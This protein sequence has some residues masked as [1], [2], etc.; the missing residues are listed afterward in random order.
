M[1]DKKWNLSICGICPEE[2]NEMSQ[3][4]VFFKGNG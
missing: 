1:R 2:V 3:Y 4:Y